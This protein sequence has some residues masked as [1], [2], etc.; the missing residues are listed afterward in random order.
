MVHAP[1]H[2]DCRCD[3][4]KK[5]YVDRKNI[6]VKFSYLKKPFQTI[7]VLTLNHI[8]HDTNWQRE[9]YPPCMVCSSYDVIS[10]CDKMTEK[11]YENP[12]S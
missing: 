12:N 5:K 10:G 2:A 6:K 7:N 3:N 9:N 1:L 8:T 11:Y 4:R